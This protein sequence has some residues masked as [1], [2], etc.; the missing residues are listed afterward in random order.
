[1]ACIVQLPYTM[2]IVQD[3]ILLVD[4]DPDLCELLVD[5][6]CDSGHTVDAVPDAEEAIE[7]LRCRDYDCVV[8]DIDLGGGQSG[9]QLCEY[10]AANR[11]DLPVAIATGAGN[12]EAAVAAIR[13]GAY[14][15]VTKPISLE[16]LEIIIERA[17]SHHR[18]RNELKRLHR[19]SS[20]PVSGG[21]IIGTSSAM[22][23]V[24]DLIDRVGPSDASVLISGESGTGKEMIARAIHDRSSAEGEFVA[25]NCAAIP[26]GL[27]ESE[28]FGHVRGAFTD[29]RRT[30]LGLFRQAA[31]GTLLLDE[32]AEMQPSL[33]AKLLRALQE[34]RV[35]PV[36]GDAEVAIEVRILAATNRDLAERVAAGA[37]REDLYFRLNVVRIAAPALRDRDGDVLLLAQHFVDQSPA[38]SKRGVYGISSGACRLL[39]AYDWPGNVR[40]LENTVER[41]IAL[42]RSAEI[43]PEDLPGAIRMFTPSGPVDRQRRLDQLPTLLEMQRN[44]VDRVLRAVGG[45]KTH[46][47]RVLGVDRRTLYRKLE[48]FHVA[49]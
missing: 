38:A 11:P 28:L 19:A 44:H 29:A 41:A 27:L 20:P 49:T 13:A 43:A 37:F 35:R 36:G 31:G 17:V 7:C 26:A 16:S 18:L 22:R 14:D 23:E 6:L 33:Q 3:R 12:T 10:V 46:A 5:A 4:D 40:E 42:T 39:R 2:Q 30:R 45:N 15:F 24:F 25:I 9:L 8:A 34:R 21:P 32:I 48:K 1:M 47:S